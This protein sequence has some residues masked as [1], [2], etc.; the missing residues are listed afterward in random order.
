MGAWFNAPPVLVQ[1]HEDFLT[2]FLR[3]RAITE[4]VK[5]DA[6]DQSLVFS[7]GTL[8]IGVRHRP[9][10]LITIGVRISTQNPFEVSSKSEMKHV[11]CLILFLGLLTSCGS[12][13][14]PPSTPA[15]ADTLSGEWVG[16]WGP[17]PSRQTAVTL[18]LRWDGT[19]LN[20]TVNPGRNAL[21]LSKASFDPQSQTVTMELD[22]PNADRE[23]VHYVVKGKVEG[24]TMSGTFDRAGETGTF[25]LEK[26]VGLF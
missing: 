7:H 8:E 23:V 6:V 5:G 19:T 4:E 2:H 1:F 21:E 20:G 17:S 12:A 11:F 9:S 24:N 13:P 25:S 3:R 15:S 26:Q 18:E 10:Q 22:G 16:Q 14:E